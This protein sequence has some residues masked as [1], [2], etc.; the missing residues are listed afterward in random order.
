MTAI[1]NLYETTK[2][3]MTN[4]A[5]ME[6][7]LKKIRNQKLRHHLEEMQ[8]CCIVEVML[9]SDFLFEVSTCENQDEINFLVEAVTE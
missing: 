3:L 9:M 8:K 5:D 2:R 6:A 4:I 7:D 1:D